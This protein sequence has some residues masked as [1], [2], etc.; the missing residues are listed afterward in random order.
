MRPHPFWRRFAILSAESQW[1]SDPERFALPETY[2]RV[3]EVI[4]WDAAIAFGMGVWEEKRPPSQ[5][6]IFGRGMIY[7]PRALDGRCGKDLVRLAG[8][9]N[10]ALLVEEFSGMQLA[11]SN[12]KSASIRRRNRAVITQFNQ[13][14]KDKIVAYSFGLTDRQIRRIINKGT[15]KNVC[16]Q[17]A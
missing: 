13:G 8:P 2:H 16:Q 12:I 3:A 9:E 10:A 6:Q 17:D 7:I 4:G 5:A 11:F 15:A 14:L 1:E